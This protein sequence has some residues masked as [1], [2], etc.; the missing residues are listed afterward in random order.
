MAAGLGRTGQATE[1][2]TGPERHQGHGSRMCHG[3]SADGFVEGAYVEDCFRRGSLKAVA[4]VE[5]PLGLHS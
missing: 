5:I 3:E 4:R 2:R 1:G